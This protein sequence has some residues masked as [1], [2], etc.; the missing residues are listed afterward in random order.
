MKESKLKFMYILGDGMG[1]YP[2]DLEISLEFSGESTLCQVVEG[3]KMFLVGVG[4][5]TSLVDAIDYED[6]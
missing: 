6:R 2:E 3:F 4:Y 5:S 1:E